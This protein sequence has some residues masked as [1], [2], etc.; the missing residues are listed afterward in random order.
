MIAYTGIA[1]NAA[2]CTDVSLDEQG[3]GQEIEW[4]IYTGTANEITFCLPEL[5]VQRLS[6][7]GNLSKICY[8]I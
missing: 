2:G 4:N 5:P 7:A 1:G 6:Y 3:G 8:W